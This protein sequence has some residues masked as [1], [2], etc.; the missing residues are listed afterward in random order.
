[1]GASGCVVVGVLSDKGGRSGRS[2]R[3]WSGGEHKEDR[4]ISVRDL[5]GSFKFAALI[6][7][8][9]R[10]SYAEEKHKACERVGV[11]E[12]FSS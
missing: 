2:G 7:A 10:C 6:P 9:L 11:N 4:I 12:K 5:R 1:M 8:D 3:Q